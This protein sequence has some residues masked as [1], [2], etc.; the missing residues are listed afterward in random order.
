MGVIDGDTYQCL[1]GSCVKFRQT[2]AVV[3]KDSIRS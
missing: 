2:A 3:V 1:V